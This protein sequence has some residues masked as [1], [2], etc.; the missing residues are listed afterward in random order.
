MK[1]AL[2]IVGIAVGAVVALLVLAGVAVA[3][4]VDLDKIVNEQLAKHRPEIEERLGRKVEVG[5]VATRLFPSLTVQ[6]ESVTVAGEKDGDPAL[7]TVGPIRVEVALWDAIVSR[8]ERIFVKEVVVSD[9]KVHLV[10]HADGTL[11]YDDILARQQKKAEGAPEPEPTKEEKGQGLGGFRLGEFR[12]ENAELRMVDH[13]TSTG[14]PAE[15]H[16]RKLNLRV[17]DVRGGAPLTVRLDAALFADATNFE[18]DA[19]YGPLPATAEPPEEAAL[20]ALRLKMTAVDLSRLSPY[21]PASA[22]ARIDSAL[23]S[24]DWELGQMV[25]GKPFGVKGFFEVKQLQLEGGAKFDLRLA[26]DL[27]VDPAGPGVDIAAFELGVG[28]VKLTASGALRTLATSPTFRDFKVQSTTLSPDALLSYYPPA[29]ADLPPGT[30]FSGAARFDVLASGDAQKQTLNA[31][32]DLGPL[33]V[34]YP[35]TLVKPAGVPLGVEVKGEFTSKDAVLE[36]LALVLDEL[37]LVVRGT[38]KDFD[39]PAFNLTATARPFSLDRIVRLVPSVREGLQAQKANASGKGRLDAH[40]KGTQQNLDAALD[41]SLDGMKL[42]VPGTRLDG[43]LRLLATAQGDPSKSLRAKLD[44]DANNAVIRIKDVMDKGL[45]TPLRL[46]L[47]L[48]R[49]ANR[50]DVEKFDLRLAEL[51]L[52]IQGGI[53]YPKN[54]VDVRVQM[55]RLDLEK[56]SR[57]VTALPPAR[58]KGSHLGMKLE[59]RGDPDRMETLT[60]AMTDVDARIGRSDLRGEV[61]LKNPVRPDLTMKVRS[62]VL[63][64]DELLGSEEPKGGKEPAQKAEAPKQQK[65]PPADDPELRKYKVFAQLDADRV[66]YEGT[67]LTKFRGVVRLEDGRLLLEDATFNAYGGTVSARGTEAEIWRGQMPFKANVTATGIE[68][69]QALSDQTRYGNVL[70]GKTDLNLRLTGKGYQTADLEQFLHGAIDLSMKQGRFNKGS[71]TDGVVSRLDGLG[72]IPGVTLQPLRGEN[73]IKDLVA[74]LEVKDGKLTLVQPVTFALDQGRATLGGAVGI[75]G[76]LFLDGTYHL[77]GTVVGS[78][79]GGKC[80][81]DKELPIPLAIVGSIDGPEYQPRPAAA[82]R[83]LVEACVTQAAADAAADKLKSKLGVT[84]PTNVDDAK[85][86]AQAEA[87]R[88]RAEAEAKARAEAEKRAAEQKRKAEEAA[89]SKAKDAL[90]KGFGF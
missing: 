87:D 9:L 66:I 26:T 41:F 30:R 13:A 77:P 83:S 89:K 58:V 81:S 67:E 37:E 22:G 20:R 79:T 33:D 27:S 35:G 56:F 63:D 25:P 42:D 28:E 24:A 43:D 12:V 19:T 90:K 36:R 65:A 70:Q 61:L 78:A 44:F 84:V 16:I 55:D 64:L 76:K 4:F 51:G 10:R 8:G 57:T 62:K 2:K 38:V 49:T 46:D 52:R 39:K 11:S 53:D 73:A 5:K 48:Q 1:R 14:K 31:K 7:M 85:Q 18:L 82:V 60:L 71:V 59:V 69:G 74:K 45:K 15:S 21:L 80:R 3:L 32:V 50:L 23:A 68:L 6:L 54:V 29:R 86:R 40:L 34:H 47:A 72:K 88:A 17:S 75:G